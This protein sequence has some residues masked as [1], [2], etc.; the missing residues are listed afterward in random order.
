MEGDRFGLTKQRTRGL[1]NK[2]RG[3]TRP[4]GHRQGR[5]APP[6]RPIA[7]LKKRSAARRRPARRG[8]N[9]RQRAAILRQP[10]NLAVYLALVNPGDVG[11]ARRPRAAHLTHGH[12]LSI[13]G[14]YFKS[15]PYGVRRAD[16]TTRTCDEVSSSPGAQAEA[17]W[18]APRRT[19]TLD[20]AA[21]RSDRGRGG[22]I[23]ARDLRDIARHS[24]GGRYPSRSAIE[25]VVRPDPKA[26]RGRAAHMMLYSRRRHAPAIDKAVSPDAGRSHNHNHAGIAV[27]AREASKQ[28]FKLYAHR[29]R[30]NAKIPRE[31][32]R[33]SR[34]LRDHRVA[35][36]PPQIIGLSPNK[37]IAAARGRPS[38]APASSPNYNAVPVSIRGSLSIRRGLRIGTPAVTSRAWHQ[39]MEQ[40]AGW[41]SSG[42]SRTPRRQDR[43][44][45]SR[46]RGARPQVLGL[47]ARSPS[48]PD[49]H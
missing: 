13:T 16:H 42:S 44:R 8:R 43:S 40:L 6:F 39:G 10:A 4:A 29:H 11:W 7:R 32:A 19:A 18:P 47:C 24:R 14:K 26:V 2:K 37:N 45:R 15:G 34:L 31:G 46:A 25:D 27:A 49:S 5:G 41:I 9:A 20:F 22:A 35:Q 28:S 48:S 30:G 23:F 1:A 36:T 12:T 38:L 21:F 33:L 17:L 3:T